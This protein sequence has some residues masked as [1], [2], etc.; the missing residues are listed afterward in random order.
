M[1]IGA[2]GHPRTK[3][4]PSLLCTVSS[5][6]CL[7]RHV[8]C[9]CLSSESLLVETSSVHPNPPLL[10]TDKAPK[11]LSVTG[12]LLLVQLLKVWLILN[13]KWHSPSPARPSQLVWLSFLH[14]NGTASVS[15]PGY[16]YTLLIHSQVTFYPSYPQTASAGSTH[17]FGQHCQCCSAHPDQQHPK[18]PFKS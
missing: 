7:S 14:K 12:G 9:H 15:Q 13:P 5:P 10:C 8:H 4:F 17:T 11:H 18:P 16:F 1:E 3:A 6:F 2:P